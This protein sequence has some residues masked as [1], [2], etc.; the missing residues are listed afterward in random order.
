MTT[1]KFALVW[2]IIF[3]IIGA[4]GFI[5]GLMHP[6]AMDDPDIAMRTMYGRE[7]GLFPVNLLHSIVHLLF[8]L[9]GV[10]AYRSWDAAKTYA[11][12]TAVVYAVFVV[13]GLIPGLDTTFGL[14][15]LFSHDVWLHIILA[16]G[17]AYFGFIHR[18]TDTRA[19]T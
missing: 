16:A 15:P 1:R 13:M 4:G 10:L 7:L 18:D 2:G 5:P 17:A 8:G 11:K 19:R 14:V 6:P 3:L 12:V 9:W